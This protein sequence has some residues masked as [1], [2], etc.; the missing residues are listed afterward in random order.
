MSYTERLPEPQGA[1][2]DINER[3]YI[4]QLIGVLRTNFGILENLIANSTT[5][6]VT[7]GDKGDITVSGSGA[8]WTI[9]NS[10][11]S[12]KIADGSVSNTEFQY[13][14]G[15]TSN[16]QTQLTDLEA[17]IIAYSIAFGG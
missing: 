10:M 7:D 11:D 13:L 4:E 12:T 6:G 9:D 5:G 17:Q 3:R 2:T 14:N 15:A 8:T 16:I 1:I